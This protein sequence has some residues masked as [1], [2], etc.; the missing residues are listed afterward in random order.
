MSNRNVEILIHEMSSRERRKTYLVVI[1][2]TGS[3]GTIQAVLELCVLLLKLCDLLPQVLGPLLETVDKGSHLP[4]LTTHPGLTGDT[5]GDFAWDVENKAASTASR[6]GCALH[7]LDL[8]INSN[9]SVWCSE[10]R[11]A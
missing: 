7:L 4:C 1:Y 10:S 11:L 2:E 9:V 5:V 6:I 3:V 8:E